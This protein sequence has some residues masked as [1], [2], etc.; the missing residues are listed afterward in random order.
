MPIRGYLEPRR[1]GGYY[2]T[3]RP[4][5]GNVGIEA[6]GPVLEGR[7]SLDEALVLDRIRAL[8]GDGSV[9]NEVCGPPLIGRPGLEGAKRGRE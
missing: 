9:G 5:L 2:A 7:M 4:I 1:G 6:R 8:R 3:G